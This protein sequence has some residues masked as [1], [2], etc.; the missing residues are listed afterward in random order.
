METLREHPVQ[1]RPGPA[2]DR[3]PALDEAAL[4]AVVASCP[5]AVIVTDA[6]GVVRY[7]NGK[8]VALFG[9]EPDE[10]IGCPFSTF[11]A[12]DLK[13]H[14]PGRERAGRIVMGQRRDGTRFPMTLSGR[15]EGAGRIYHA[16]DLT[17]VERAEHRLHSLQ[18]ELS[19]VS[20]M[21]ALGTLATTFASELNPPMS[22]AVNF[23][24]AAQLLLEAESLDTLA[25]RDAINEAA[26]QVFRA[27]EIVHRLREAVAPNAPRHRVES[28]PELI[29]EARGLALVGAGEHGVEIHVKLDRQAERVLAD[30]IQVQQVMLNLIRNAIEAM[31]SS[32]IRDLEISSRREPDGFVRL[33]VAD[34]GPGLGEEVSARLF[35]PF[36][37]T[38]EGGLGLGLSICRTIVEA[39]GGRIWT[40]PSDLGG[41]AFHF[42]L[43]D[44]ARDDARAG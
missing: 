32:C 17:D 30:G 1:A 20:G 43:V 18:T 31:D 35:E 11:L 6:Q 38:K 14:V 2:T 8:A 16:R 40:E 7:V 15:K 21:A 10:A 39:H 12:D 22:A 33:T 41:T 25:L 36:T 3:R 29:D 5:D 27:G 24:D 42:T 4:R 9:H 23:L 13:D 44:A 19:R 37:T 34:S 28:L 26:A